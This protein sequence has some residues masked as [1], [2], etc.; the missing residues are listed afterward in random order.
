MRT[1]LGDLLDYMEGAEEVASGIAPEYPEYRA[2][3]EVVWSATSMVAMASELEA[4]G[5]RESND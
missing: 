1:V 4:Y 5:E 3:I 2:M